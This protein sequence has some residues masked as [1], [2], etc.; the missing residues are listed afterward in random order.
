MYEIGSYFVDEFPKNRD[1]IVEALEMAKYYNHITGIMEL[2]VTLALEKMNKF[3]EK[4]G[5]QLSFTAWMMKCIAQAASEHKIIQT[6]RKG[7]RKSIVFNDVDIKCMV[8]KK[9]NGR[10]IPLHYIFRKVNEK[11]FM[12]LHNEMRTVQQKAEETRKGEKKVKKRQSNI[13]K[14]PKFVRMII[15]HFI[16]TNPFR[17]KK[18]LGTIGVSAIG[19]FGKG[20]RGWA[21]PKTM[22]QTQF[23]LGAIVKKAVPH[24]EKGYEFRDILNATIKINHDLVDGGPAVRFAQ[25]R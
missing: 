18:N 12:E 13:M 10:N 3:K 2:D 25:L 20:M 4:N 15:W 24:P 23:M 7:R 8:E 6:F 21:I 19:M 16:M 1:I 9:I 22:H 17:V 11:S 5:D 14:L